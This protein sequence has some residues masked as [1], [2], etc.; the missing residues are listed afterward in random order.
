MLVLGIETATAAVSVALVRT[1]S[2]LAQILVQHSRQNTAGLVQDIA[3]LLQSLPVRG[4]DLD[5][6]AISIGPGSYTGLR[7]GLSVA[8]SLA[9]S[10]EKPLAAV[11]SLDAYAQTGRGQERSICP[12]IR[13][14][15]GE[16]YFAV[17]D[18]NGSIVEKQS[19]YHTG[20]PADIFSCFK[21]PT[22][23]LGLAE[24]LD[25]EAKN[26][27][28]LNGSHVLRDTAPEAKWTAL[29]GESLLAKGIKENVSQITPFYMHEFPVDFG[30][31]NEVT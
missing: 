19:D 7:V 31:A 22:L 21:R 27:E 24:Q 11:N 14:R 28:S 12:L 29:L 17:Y 13:F 8:K 2:L 9:Y 16:Y 1:G 5:G 25:P 6:I 20:R 23:V 18:W 10:W 15:K 26:V 30:S 3:Y 4:Q